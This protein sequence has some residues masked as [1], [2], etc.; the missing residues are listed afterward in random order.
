MNVSRGNATLVAG[1]T[2]DGTVANGKTVT[3][4]RGVEIKEPVATGT[5]STLVG[6]YIE[7]MTT[8]GTDWAI[9]SAGG[10]SYFLNTIRVADALRLIEAGGTSTADWIEI[11][12]PST[13]GTSYGIELDDNG[14]SADSLAKFAALSSAVTIQTF[15]DIP[16][17]RIFI[18]TQT[19]TAADGTPTASTVGTYPKKYEVWDFSASITEAVYTSWAVPDDYKAGTALTF[20]VV[21]TEGSSSAN[22]WIGAIKFMSLGDTASTGGTSTALSATIAGRSS[23]TNLS[24]ETIGSSS[25]DVA[26]GDWVLINFERTGASGSDT[27]PGIIRVI[28]VIVEYV[29]NI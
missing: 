6:L 4:Y 9:Y 14:P 7:N 11:K 24:I 22:N 18:P 20:K 17:G 13:V 21:Y 5:I 27:H 28:G 15:V 29:R 2:V 1:F 8:G 12:A 19:F 25:V 16:T 3:D 26:A 23:L 10:D